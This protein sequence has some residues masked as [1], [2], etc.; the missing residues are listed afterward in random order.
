VPASGGAAGCHVEQQKAQNKS[1]SM[2]LITV[3]LIAFGGFTELYAAGWIVV[4][5]TEGQRHNMPG[6][7]TVDRTRDPEGRTHG[8]S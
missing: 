1:S 6:G 8:H 3:P 2:D 5:W 7:T 4:S